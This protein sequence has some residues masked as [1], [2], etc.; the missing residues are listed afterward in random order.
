M[1]EDNVKRL[2]FS[3]MKFLNKQKTNHQ[4]EVLEQIEVAQQ[5]CFSQFILLVFSIRDWDHARA[6]AFY[7]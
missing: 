5:V 1:A 7:P 4:G 3:I 2:I 6:R